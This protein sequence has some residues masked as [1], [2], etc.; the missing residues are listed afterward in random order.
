MQLDLARTQ[1]VAPSL[2][3]DLSSQISLRIGLVVNGILMMVMALAMA[4]PQMIP[5]F[6][7]PVPGSRTPGNPIDGNP[8][9]EIPAIPSLLARAIPDSRMVTPHR[10][11]PEVRT[12]IFLPRRK[13]L[14]SPLQLRQEWTRISL[15]EIG[16]SMFFRSSLQLLLGA[17]SAIQLLA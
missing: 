5:S 7:H 4:T 16:P 14:L 6:S 11:I 3:L 9:K 2:S 8:Q 13:R 10:E 17:P 15:S 1:K 12:L